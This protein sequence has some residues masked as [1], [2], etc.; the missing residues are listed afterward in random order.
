MAARAAA[1]IHGVGSRPCPEAC[2]AP[3]SPMDNRWISGGQRPARRRRILAKKT[4]ISGSDRGQTPGQI[5]G[6]VEGHQ[7][8]RLL[9]QPCECRDHSDKNNA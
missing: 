3:L 4:P 8:P 2:V 9:T 5:P 1:R 7:F 6:Q